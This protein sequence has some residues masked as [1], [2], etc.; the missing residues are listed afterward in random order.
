MAFSSL[1]FAVMSALVKR[2][3]VRLPGTEIGLVRF[4]IG[5][6]VVALV[7]TQLRLR[8]SNWRGLTARGV[9]G[10]LAVA[11]FFLA[12]EH[13]QVGFATLLNYTSPVFTALWAAMFYKEAVTRRT[14]IALVLTT[15]GL[16]FVVAGNAPP[17]GFALQGWV[18]VG[19][20]AAV[21][22]GAA[23]ATIREVRKTDGSWE[24]LGAFCIGGMLV[25]GVPS[26]AHWVT[27]TGVE[28]L[29]L[30]AVGLV[31]VV[32]QIL[33]T[34]ALRHLTAAHGGVVMQLTPVATM[35][36][37]FFVFAEIPPALGLLGAGVTLGGVVLASL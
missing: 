16:A 17:H 21:L 31:S 5:L 24:I 36:I 8:V 1:L 12:I 32:A 25:C 18:L 3:A 11:C 13:L 2:A 20:S 7:A 6:V 19:L 10:G 23:V 26:V 22:S 30:V 4:A 35:V 33:M 28:W 9:F 29:V 27:P 37:G 15:L 34:W 14:V